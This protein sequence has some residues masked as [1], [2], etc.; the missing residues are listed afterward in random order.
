[1]PDEILTPP[2]R[3]GGTAAPQGSVAAQARA[4]ARAAAQVRAGRVPAE[5]PAT[6]EQE[7][8]PGAAREAQ[9]ERRAARAG[10]RAK[11]D[12]GRVGSGG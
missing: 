8:G 4:A 10:P 1:M 6:Q 9:P 2:L 12:R 7:A 11:V 3:P 5:R